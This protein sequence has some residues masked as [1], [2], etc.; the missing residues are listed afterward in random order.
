MLRPIVIVSA[1]TCTFPVC[2]KGGVGSIFGALISGAVGKAIGKSA[3][4][5]SDIEK[6]LVR[7]SDQVNKNLPMAV[8]KETRWDNVTPGPGR[9]FTFNYTLVSTA[10][11]DLD[12][13]YF[14]RVM[15]PTV[16]NGACSNKDMEIFFKY[17]VTVSYAYRVKEG[18]SVGRV[19]VTPRDC[20]FTS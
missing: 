14:F 13:A 10:K 6:I 16:K 17:G 7:A 19:E 12:V 4:T 9:R 15:T 3:A 8:D 2:A 5:D 18:F 20:G 11:A 1:L